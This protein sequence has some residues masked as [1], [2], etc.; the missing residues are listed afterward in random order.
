MGQSNSVPGS[1]NVPFE[2]WDVINTPNTILDQVFHKSDTGDYV[3]RRV[4]GDPTLFELLVADDGARLRYTFRK[5]HSQY[6]YGGQVFS[7]VDNLLASLMHSGLRGK[8][9]VIHLQNCLADGFRASLTHYMPLYSTPMWYAGKIKRAEAKQLV[10]EGGKG[11]FLVRMSEEDH[12]YS[13]IVADKGQ[14]STF[15]IQENEDGSCQFG[16]HRFKSLSAL[17]HKIGKSGLKGKGGKLHL[18]NPILRPQTEPYEVSMPKTPS[19]SEP[20]LS[21][22]PTASTLPRKI[23]QAVSAAAGPRPPPQT[24]WFAGRYSRQQAAAVLLNMPDNKAGDYVFHQHVETDTVYYLTVNDHGQAAQYK[25]LVTEGQ[26]L[27]GPRLFPSLQLLRETAVKTG[28][29]GKQ[30]Q[31]A[32]TRPCGQFVRDLAAHVPVSEDGRR[33]T[34]EPTNKA[35]LLEM[36][37]RASLASATRPT[38]ASIARAAGP[39]T[40]PT[41]ASAPRRSP[42]RAPNNS[43]PATEQGPLIV[44]N[45]KASETV[46]SDDEA[47][48]DRD[49]VLGSHA[50][51]NQAND[52][53]MDDDEGLTGVSMLDETTGS[54]LEQLDVK[55]MPL[56]VLGY[57]ELP[58]REV[59][60]SDLP[61]HA[62]GP[63]LNRFRDVLPHP[64]TRVKLPELPEDKTLEYI[65]ANWVRG[66]GGRQARAYVAAQAPKDTGLFNFWRM[67]LH[68]K[69]TTVVMVTGLIEG[70]KNKCQRYWP[71]ELSTESATNEMVFGPP[72]ELIKI[73]TTKIERKDGFEMS[74][75][76]VSCNGVQHELVHFWFLAWPDHGVPTK[77]SGE[78]ETMQLIHMLKTLRAYRTKRDNQES[79]CMVHCSAGIGRTGT[80]IVLDHAMRALEVGDNVDLLAII[81]ECRE[82]RM[83]LVQHVVQ[84]RYLYQAT[85]DY[86]ELL[87]T[88][89]LKA[90]L[91]Q[92]SK[93]ANGEESNAQHR[94]NS[95][96]AVARPTEYQ[97][98]EKDKDWELHATDGNTKVF[99]LKKG[100]LGQAADDHEAVFAPQ[101]QVDAGEVIASPVSN[102]PEGDATVEDSVWYRSNYTRSQ[103]EELLADAAAGTF[104][105]RKSSKPGHFALSLQTGVQKKIANLLI[106]PLKTPHGLM[107]KLGASGKEAFG[108]IAEL[109]KHYLA[110]GIPASET[111][112]QIIRL[113]QPSAGDMPE[114]EEA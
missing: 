11:S 68:T 51:A 89:R 10:Q 25:I 20:P 112:S 21:A 16:S 101:E 104:I 107:Y 64:L 71:A 67:I 42:S 96:F 31:L 84:Y 93:P 81:R 34:V 92:G 87:R 33:P 74:T 113:R 7:N 32:L 38:A 79:P 54:L 5:D 2:F 97:R 61:P 98:Y 18:T 60:G 53:D 8:S 30:G 63:R 17:A 1:E 110:E 66:Y 52:D 23:P 15:L 43:P 9:G 56:D 44:S 77:P 83:A 27:F 109:V 19:G 75:L 76:Q 50:T 41:A 39:A 35:E 40:M 88:Q 102:K 78:M 59:D 46:V 29:K 48:D 45:R 57:K 106:I 22:T 114:D 4:L 108:T 49:M 73:R 85:C 62:L 55:I 12:S 3:I 47:E 72:R 105:V 100:A 26:F 36:A 58:R 80:V 14:V 37:K 70:G 69:A 99:T 65:N 90:Q 24:D 13:L 6:H 94:H 28:L 86:Y 111:S 82:D 95:I 103:V 91:D